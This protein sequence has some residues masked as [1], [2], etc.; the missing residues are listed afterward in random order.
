MIRSTRLGTGVDPS[1]PD[2]NVA[3][4]D[5]RPEVMVNL[6]AIA[7]LVRHSPLGVPAALAALAGHMPAHA[8]DQLAA[9]VYGEGNH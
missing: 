5:G 1:V 7:G 2:W 8:L 4:I 9:L 3:T 6:A